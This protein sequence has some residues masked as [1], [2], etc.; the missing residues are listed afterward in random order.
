MI[1]SDEWNEDILNAIE[2]CGEFLLLLSAA[3]FA[4]DFMRAEVKH[5]FVHGKR[6]TVIHLEPKLKAERLDMRVKNSQHLIWHG[7]EEACFEEL[8]ER[9]S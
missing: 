8:V 9:L 3:A 6:V 5:A 4:S 7:R 2:A 1:R